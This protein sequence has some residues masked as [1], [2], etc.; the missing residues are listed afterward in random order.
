MIV[1]SYGGGTQS[2]AIAAAILKGLLPCPDYI[3]MADTG[4]EATET[5]EY[6]VCNVLPRFYDAGLADLGFHIASHD[7]ATVDMYSKKGGLLIPAY[8]RTGKLPTFCSNEWKTRVVHR[9]LRGLGIEKCTM[10]LGMST[11]EVERLKPSSV[12]W[13]TN[14]WPLCFSLPMNRA[15]CRQFVL[16]AGWPDPP[17]SCCYICPHR[18]DKQWQRLKVYYP[19]DFAKA[20]KIDRD[21]R[22][23]DQ[24]GG[25]WLHE[26]RKP[27]DEVDFTGGGDEPT[28]FGCDSGF[29]WT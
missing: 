25:V 15:A 1:W 6:L 29:C 10:W 24:Q 23:N 3:V 9:Y 17:K 22:A 2:V 8:T 16:N 11:D 20:A 27:L 7:L 12:G 19:E 26:S 18:R 4:L 28:L 5:W 13:I 14:E 21:I